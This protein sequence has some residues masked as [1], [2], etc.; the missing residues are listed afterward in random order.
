VLTKFPRVR[1]GLYVCG[2]E[3]AHVLLVSALGL[4][5]VSPSEPDK[6]P[7]YCP[8]RVPLD[9]YA[10]RRHLLP[11]IPNTFV[12]PPF[13]STLVWPPLVSHCACDLQDCTRAGCRFWPSSCLCAGLRCLAV[14]QNI[15]TRRGDRIIFGWE[16]F[17]FCAPRSY[18]ALGVL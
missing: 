1:S 12:H 13:Q 11:L 8:L 9:G 16:W 3:S 2:P 6:A 4:H 14:N 18:Q 7:V 17:P 10:A 15:S 5:H